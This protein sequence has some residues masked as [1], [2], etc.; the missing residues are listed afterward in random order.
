[1]ADAAVTAA[2]ADMLSMI[3]GKNGRLY[4]YLQQK[5]SRREPRT[6]FLS[7]LERERTRIARELHAGAGQ[8]LAGIKL[9]LE[10]LRECADDLPPA[11][12]EALGRLQRLAEQALDQV[13]SVSH[14]LHPPEWQGLTT[15]EALRYL[16][17]SSGIS[18]RL[19]VK[20]DIQPLA[21]E[22]SHLVK[23][24]LYRCAQECLS[25]VLRH[26][27]ATHVAVS[28]KPGG[29]QSVQGQSMIELRIEDNGRGFAEPASG[30]KG[31]GLVALREHAES[32]GGTC[33]FSSSTA[34]VS[35][36]V[37]VPLINE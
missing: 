15:S 36:I 2:W 5:P 14:G 28:L 4:G 32:L 7:Q 20:I 37:R 31:I 25:N 30:R 3:G 8:P 17:Q 24:T 22:P 21:P 12:R 35:V 10:M 18:D 16:F 23:V 29:Q 9:N 34:G 6:S 27:G 1:M 11:G 33:E 26:S 19:D 13:R